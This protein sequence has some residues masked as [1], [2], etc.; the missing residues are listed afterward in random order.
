MYDIFKEQADFFLKPLNE[1]ATIQ[2]KVLEEMTQKQSDLLN[3]CWKDSCDYAQSIS[4]QKDLDQVMKSNQ[5][6]VEAMSK[7]WQA[8]ADASVEIISQSNLKIGEVLQDTFKVPG[9]EAMMG[10]VAKAS[11]ASKTTAKKTTKA[12]ASTAQK[13]ASAAKKTTT[14]KAPAKKTAS[15]AA[16][17]SSPAE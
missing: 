4:S 15:T 5:D 14:R 16:S 12:A 11:S 6:L 1:I 9:A 13:T 7:R 2:A 3:G 17:D 10:M 8:T